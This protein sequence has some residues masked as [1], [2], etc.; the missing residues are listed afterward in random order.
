MCVILFSCWVVP[1]T[2]TVWYPS[3]STQR[4]SGHLTSQS[5]ALKVA[6]SLALLWVCVLFVC[7]ELHLLYWA[8]LFIVVRNCLCCNGSH[9]FCLSVSECVCLCVNQCATNPNLYSE[10]CMGIQTDILETILPLDTSP[11]WTF[12]CSRTVPPSQ[13]ASSLYRVQLS[14]TAC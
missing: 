4:C 2:W 13:L 3:E 14:F 5:V 11:P 8:L 9:R 10:C 7:C 6:T 1:S 12:C